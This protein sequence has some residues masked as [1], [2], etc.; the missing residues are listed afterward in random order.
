[1]NFDPSD[2]PARP[3]TNFRV[4]IEDHELSVSQVSGLGS[5][6]MLAADGGPGASGYTPL[7]MRRALGDARELYEWRERILNGER[8]L[9]EVVVQLLDAPAGS[10]VPNGI[11]TRRGLVD[12]QD[13]C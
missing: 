3:A 5:E 8:D 10:P 12:G 11:Y 13:R 1:M 4:L 6:T 7:L 9:R 2:G